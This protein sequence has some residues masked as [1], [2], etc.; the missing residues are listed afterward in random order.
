[1]RAPAA[2]QPVRP[3]A[4]R[5]ER[6][7]DAFGLLLLCLVATYVCG[8]LTGYHGVGAVGI[9]ALYSLSAIV[10][11][12]SAGAARSLIAWGTG[13]A[14]LGMLLAIVGA[15]TASRAVLGAAA[16]VE[17]LL[18]TVGA[19]MVLRAVVTQ[20]RVGFRTILGAVSVYLSLCLLFAFA[21][22][23][24]DRIQGP[25]F[26][27]AAHVHAGDFL[28]FSITTLTTTGYGNLVPAGQP[29]KMVAALEM[30]MG[31]I[32]LVTLIARLVSMWSPGEWLREGGGLAG[33][34][35]R[36]RSQ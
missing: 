21:Y 1:V 24:L 18:L 9:A 26:G 28:F 23:A 12:A 5:L 2:A 29:G 7:E 19:L 10:A 11:L 14:A 20:E 4:E 6:L 34:R 30:L 32:F 16:C 8:S 33:R 25:V 31:Q 13:A 3:F 35:E 27:Q 15:A 36:R 17:A 22:V